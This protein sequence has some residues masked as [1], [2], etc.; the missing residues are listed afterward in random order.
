ML[1]SASIPGIFPPVYFNVEVNGKKYDEMHVDGGVIAG[2]FGYGRLFGEKVEISRQQGV[3]SIYV[4]RNGKQEN[5]PMAVPR[6]VIKIVG[7]SFSTLMKA[8]SWNDLFRIYS[9]ASKDGVDFNY[10]SIPIDYESHA[11][12]MFDK[13]EMKKLF[14]LGFEMAKGGYKWHKSPTATSGLDEE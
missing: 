3:C 13:A 10:V 1:A 4:I 9:V 5:E 11:K 2:V 6:R 7:Q 14:G 8:Q 12:E